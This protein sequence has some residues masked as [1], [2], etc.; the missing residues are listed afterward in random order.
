MNGS[1]VVQVDGEDEPR[2]FTDR[3]VIGRDISWAAI[4]LTGDK[5][6]SPSHATV[7][8]A[9]DGSWV[10]EDNG[11]TNGTWAG[12]V[13]VYKAR[14]GKGDRLRVGRTVL[15]FIPAGDP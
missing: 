11:S 9:G 13:R 14:L 4:D 5:Y 3:F 7:Y 8:P 1:L 10:I 15:T 6:V 2:V 12:S